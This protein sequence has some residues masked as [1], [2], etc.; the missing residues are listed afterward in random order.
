MAKTRKI[1]RQQL[2]LEFVSVVFAVLLA[3]LLNS[4]RESRQISNSVERVKQ[5][6]I[7]EVQENIKL[8]KDSYAYRQKLVSD[9]QNNRHLVMSTAISEL[10]YDV[11]TDKGLK[12]LVQSALLSYGQWIE[13]VQV[14][15]RD[16]N[17]YLKMDRS[18]LNIEIEHDT[19]RLFG[20]GNIILKSP[21][22]DL[23]NRS[24]PMAQATGVLVEMDLEV[25]DAMSK[26]YTLNERYIKMSDQ[27]ISMIYKGDD[28][29]VSVLQDMVSLEKQIIDA[30]NALLRLLEE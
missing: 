29:I 24:W 11:T 19:L 6:I 4:W 17:R 9:L 28:G 20:T 12:E 18:V 10:D 22:T 25:V 2:L 13:D 7:D 27:A 14:I 23:S 15:S 21:A 30:N 3:L 16:G 26:V 1:N 8:F 5:T